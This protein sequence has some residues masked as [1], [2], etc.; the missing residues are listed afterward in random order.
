VSPSL[1]AMLLGY[2]ARA[3]VGGNERIFPITRQHVHRLVTRAFRIAGVQKPRGVG[4]VHVL[5]HSGALERLRRTGNPRAVQ[6]HLG[7]ASAAMT[8]RYL[9]TLAETEALRIQQSVDVW[10][11]PGGQMSGSESP[12]PPGRPHRGHILRRVPYEDGLVRDGEHA[13]DVETHHIL[14]GPRGD[15]WLILT[16]EAAAPLTVCTQC[17]ERPHL[18]PGEITCEKLQRYVSSAV[19]IATVKRETQ[20]GKFF[21]VFALRRPPPAGPWRRDSWD[22]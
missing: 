11:E 22:S 12:R 13:W 18:C 2:S 4:A 14:L 16:P 9:R 21:P 7:H 10:M 6:L 5:R 17:D 19:H 3:G 8:L 1:A 20:W 15:L